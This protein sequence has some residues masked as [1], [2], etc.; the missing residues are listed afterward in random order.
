MV[1]NKINL[2]IDEVRKLVVAQ[3]FNVLDHQN[4]LIRYAAAESLGRCVQT[5]NDAKFLSTITQ[6]CFEKL[7]TARDALTRTGYSLAIGCIH[8]YVVGMGSVPQ[9]KNNISLLLALAEDHSSPSVQLWA[10]HALTLIVES[11]GPMFRP[12]V[13]PTL[14]QCLKI[15]MALSPSLIDIHQS[16]AKCLSAIITTI[17]PEFQTSSTHSINEI[18]LMIMI[19]CSILQEHGDFLIKSETIACLQ[20]LHMFDR[21]CYELNEL[22][23][24]LCD[25]FI[26]SRYLLRKA[27]I[28]CFQQIAQKDSKAL[29]E[30]GSEWVAQNKSQQKIGIISNFNL[31]ANHQFPGILV[32]L[33]DYETNSSNMN[34]IKKILN[35]LVQHVDEKN[36]N[37]WITLCKE[38][39]SASDAGSSTIDSNEND[40]DADDGDFEESGF[41][42]NHNDSLNVKLTYRW[43]TRVFIMNILYKIISTCSQSLNDAAIH[44]DLNMAREKRLKHQDQDFLCLHLPDLVRMSFI[45]AT[46]D[47]DQLRMEGLKTLELVID[48]FAHVPEPE[49]ENHVILEQYQAQVG[50]ALRPAFA[51]DTPSHVTAMAC[52]VCSAWIGSG[53]ARD[54]NDLRRVHQL[55][56]SSLEK[57]H[58]HSN[59]KI[60][61]ESAST[62]EKLA[63][64]KAWAEVYVVAMLRN[65]QQQQ[66]EM[67]S[68]SVTINSESLL[69]LV[70]PQ[71]L[72]LSKYWIFAL[73]DHAL[74]TLPD[75]YYSQIPPDGSTFFN[76][77]T[78]DIV[79]P[80]YRA[81]WPSI[82]NAAALWLCC[83]DKGFEQLEND[84]SLNL[85]RFEQFYLLFGVCIESLSNPKSTEQVAYVSTYLDSLKEL[86]T[87]NEVTESILSKD[88]QLILE[89][90]QVLH[91]LLL[92][93]EV[94]G[95]QLVITEII[96]SLIDIQIRM[97][98][99]GNESNKSLSSVT[100]I[101]AHKSIVYSI[102]EICLAI[103]VRQLP[104]L[105]PQLAKTPEFCF[106][107]SQK[108]TNYFQL[109][110]NDNA[111]I[112]ANVLQ[113]LS[114]LCN[115]C[116][117]V[118]TVAI[119][120]TI[121]Y[122]IIGVFCELS[123]V[124]QTVY[125]EKL[126]EKQPIITFLKCIKNLCT[127]PMLMAHN[128]NDEIRLK[129]IQLL[130]TAIARILD[131]SKTSKQAFFKCFF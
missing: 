116:Q 51:V 40:H 9:L 129:W 101:E 71:L 73:K 58:K 121:L 41:K 131:L 67:K 54:L 75:E 112:I 64:L 85:S 5:I 72:T 126:Y 6:Q 45:G 15:L 105:C 113:I 10:L 102:L 98:R 86:I 8:H 81:S 31:R 118:D 84:T 28:C 34:N 108:S 47:C 106:V 111:K 83:S 93:H 114:D 77:E 125:D 59:S 61:N 119:L 68:P 92:T 29:I 38:V 57:L 37:L 63:I 25:G 22:I 104:Q 60:Y 3:L 100:G 11:G 91:R 65:K 99:D 33:L 53:V 90:S 21:N 120:P 128:D 13:E 20:Q 80:M 95:C 48:K 17:G 50:A 94:S 76:L 122:L 44:F 96:K 4:I 103:L 70:Q 43:Q 19:A 117:P 110:N 97:K 66:E 35:C 1:E 55:L 16:I 79:R 115:V 24:I 30:Y 39:L 74:L 46:S 12:Y 88:T 14:S 56:V 26:S 2:G 18:R 82:L 123:V 36:L 127:S 89:L 49:F 78:I 32:A 130:Q 109:F 62:M 124:C 107:R 23:F 42:S 27:S 52:Q 7:R 87:H 69:D